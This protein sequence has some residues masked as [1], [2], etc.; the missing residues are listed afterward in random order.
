MTAFASLS[1][2]AMVP[3]PGAKTVEGFVLSNVV[4]GVVVKRVAAVK[5]NNDGERRSAKRS[6]TTGM[7]IAT[8]R[9]RNRNKLENMPGLKVQS[10]VTHLEECT[11]D[12][13]NLEKA[14]TAKQTD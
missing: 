13:G 5:A 14:D 7:Q 12:A 6:N 11:C 3:S 10:R 1:S 4:T 9:N 2:K 8:N